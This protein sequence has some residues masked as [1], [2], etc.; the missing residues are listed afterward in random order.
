MESD[1]TAKET[2]GRTGEK[3]GCPVTQT[4]DTLAVKQREVSQGLEIRES[5]SK[6]QREGKRLQIKYCSKKFFLIKIN[7]YIQLNFKNWLFHTLSTEF[8]LEDKENEDSY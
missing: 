3:R 6:T 8:L 5:G 4:A 2:W 1:L 7:K